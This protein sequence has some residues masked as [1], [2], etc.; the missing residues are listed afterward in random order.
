MN[1]LAESSTPVATVITS[2]LGPVVGNI[3][4]VLVVISIFS[5]GLVITLSGTRLVW[6]MARDERFPGW[7]F[8]RKVSPTRH[9]PLA[10]SLFFFIVTQA[11]LAIFAGTTDA[12]FSLF[13][14]ATLLPAMIYAGTVLMYAIKRKSLPPSQGFTLGRWEIPVI[15]LASVWLIYELLIFRDESFEQPRLYVAIMIGIGVLYLAYLLVRSG[16]HGLTMPDMT[17]VD[18]TFDADDPAPTAARGTIQH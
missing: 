18:K 10:A 14:A 2:V 15:I 6:A 12:L 11:V 13:S 9:T 4:L 7:Q 1:K 17:D 3:L 5:C 16:V 8:L